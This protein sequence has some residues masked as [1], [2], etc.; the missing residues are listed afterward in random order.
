MTEGVEYRWPV[1][2]CLHN[3]RLVYAYTLR[4]ATGEIVS[5]VPV[6]CVDCGY[7]FEQEGD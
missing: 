4:V 5:R 7:E 3:R 2:E 1:R 6:S